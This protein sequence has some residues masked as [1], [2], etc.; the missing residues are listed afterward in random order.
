MLELLR[1]H[2]LLPEHRYPL[3]NTRRGPGKHVLCFKKKKKML[4]LESEPKSRHT[5]DHA[6]LI[7][8]GPWAVFPQYADMAFK[9]LIFFIIFNI[10]CCL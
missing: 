2:I 8:I 7:W 1:V 5:R 10:V 6:S 9:L 3:S 4:E